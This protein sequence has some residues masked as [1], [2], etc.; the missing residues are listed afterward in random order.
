MFVRQ[1][2]LS[3]LHSVVQILAFGMALAK[4]DPELYVEKLNILPGKLKKVA[5]KLQNSGLIPKAHFFSIREVVDLSPTFIV[6]E[7]ALSKIIE[8]LMR[9]IRI[10]SLDNSDSNNTPKSSKTSEEPSVLALDI[11]VRLIGTLSTYGAKFTASLSNN[12]W[13]K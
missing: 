8:I 3:G 4:V 12:I 5:K 9:A 2:A 1:P 11:F 13:S 10:S 6:D 7:S